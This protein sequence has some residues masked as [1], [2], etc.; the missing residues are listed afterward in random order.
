MRRALSLD[1]HVADTYIQLGHVLKLQGKI[2]EAQA[3]YLRAVALDPTVFEGYTELFNKD[4]VRLLRND[5]P[6]NAPSGS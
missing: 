6:G 4:G 2:E 3:S 1:P 5:T